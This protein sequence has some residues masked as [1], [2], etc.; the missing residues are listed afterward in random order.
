[1]YPM[2]LMEYGKDD[3]EAV[4][5]RPGLDYSQTLPY[6][7]EIVDTVRKRKDASLFE[8]TKKF[9][10]A[11]IQH[12]RIP[13]EQINSALGRIDKKTTAAIKAACKNISLLHKKQFHQISKEWM[14]QV[15]D[16]VFVGERMTALAS[17]GCY[18]PHGVVPYPSTVLMTVIPAKI[19]GVKRVVVASP[20]PIPDIILAACK[21]AGA[22]EVYQ[23][24]GAQ[25]IAALAYGT[26]SITPVSKIVG[27]GN[28]YVQAAKMLVFGTVAIDMPAGPSEIL[29]IAD[30]KADPAFITIDILAQAEHSHDA[31]CLL[32]TNSAKLAQDVKLLI[33]AESEK[34]T[35]KELLQRSLANFTIVNT[36]SVAESIA[37]ANEYAPE[38]LEIHTQKAGSVA[39]KIS[40][41]GAIFIGPYTP[42]AAGDYASGGN[43]VLP[44]SAAAR[45]SS[46]LSV[47]DFLKSTSLQRITKAGLRRL[48]PT[49]MTLAQAEGLTEHKHSVEIR[50]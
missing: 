41:A 31:Q 12:L 13:D 26:E 25:A 8:Y 37:F 36:R 17:V 35:K 28:R 48:A 46:Q 19:A 39:K 4:I 38:H 5:A 10:S 43:H 24:G 3:L 29:I 6:V 18:V 11:E 33:E 34:S 30:E 16:G 49:V 20:P 1:M 47:R 50:L 21:I 14:T 40:N 23:V 22:D 15:D 44:T 9:D 7:K 27:P 42:N 2:K 45:F 32:V